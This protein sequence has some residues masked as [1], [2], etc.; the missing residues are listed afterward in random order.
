MSCIKKR[1]K[2][3]LKK[4]F[5]NESH[6]AQNPSFLASTSVMAAVAVGGG[7]G[8]LLEK[9]T[10]GPPF[11]AMDEANLKNKVETCLV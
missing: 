7:G 2:I 4:D 10:P 3:P 8:L 5:S 6:L 11:E 9:R 1:T